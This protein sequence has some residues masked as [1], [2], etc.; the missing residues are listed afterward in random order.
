MVADYGFENLP[1]GTAT[2]IG[3]AIDDDENVR[4][5]RLNLDLCVKVRQ[6]TYLNDTDT[7]RDLKVVKELPAT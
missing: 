7:G 6:D 4:E 5:S 1:S 2:L 3:Y